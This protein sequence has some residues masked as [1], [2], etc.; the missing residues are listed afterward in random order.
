MT[1]MGPL[2]CLILAL[3][4]RKAVMKT[5]NT[6]STMPAPTAVRVMRPSVDSYQQ[7]SSVWQRENTVSANHADHPLVDP[8]RHSQLFHH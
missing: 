1:Y 6:N 3:R 7:A 5:T 2:V 8:L 4:Q